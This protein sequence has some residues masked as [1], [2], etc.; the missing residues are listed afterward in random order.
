VSIFINRS[1]VT[2]TLADDPKLAKTKNG[3]DVVT[4]TVYNEISYN[5]YARKNY[6]RATCYG[7]NVD[8]CKELRK[9]DW[10]HIDGSLMS[11]Q[12]VSGKWYQAIQADVVRAANRPT[13]A[14][15]DE[16][17]DLAPPAADTP[18]S[19]DMTESDIPF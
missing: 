10:I 19:P 4:L 13:R 8:V 15:W 14:L 7:R 18:S 11:Q 12:D 17:Q 3:K 9:G 16:L 5:G 1:L 6:I 2:G